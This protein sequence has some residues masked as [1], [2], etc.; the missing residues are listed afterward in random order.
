MYNINQLNEMSESQLR[1]L[2]KSMGLKKVDSASHDDLV[3]QV[4]DHQAEVE[5]A[6]AP[7]PGRRRRER[8]RQPAA[9]ANGNEVTKDDAVATKNNKSQEKKKAEVIAEDEQKPI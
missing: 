3:Y 8:I 9:K 6:N 1:D 4:L 7:E 5:A 2:A